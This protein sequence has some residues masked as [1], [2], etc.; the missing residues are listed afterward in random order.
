MFRVLAL[1][2]SSH[3]VT[4]NITCLVWIKD[5]MGADR[6]EGKMF[7]YCNLLTFIEMLSV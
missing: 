1:G 2:K 7:P 3:K 5:N 4:P 6:Q